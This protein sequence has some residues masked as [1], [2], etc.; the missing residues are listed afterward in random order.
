MQYIYGGFPSFFQFD[1]NTKTPYSILLNFGI[2]RELPGSLI[3]EVDAVSRLGRRL[4]AVGDAAQVVN[5]KDTASGQFLKAAFGQ[6]E[7]VADG[8]A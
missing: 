1:S 5:F 3:I 6:L 4:L 2:Q 8:G 7:T